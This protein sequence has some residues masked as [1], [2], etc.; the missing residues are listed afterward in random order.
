MA[1]R[2]CPCCGSYRVGHNH[3]S[4]RG[5]AAFCRDCGMTTPVF[6]SLQQAEMTWNRR[7]PRGVIGEIKKERNRQITEKDYI[8]E[9]DDALVDGQLA[10]AASVY[11]S[12][13]VG[14]RAEYYPSGWVFKPTK[15]RRELIKAAALIV[16][17]IERLDREE[18]RKN[19]SSIKPKENKTAEIFR[20]QLNKEVKTDG[21]FQKSGKSDG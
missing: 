19:D 17:E 9:H 6:S 13:R 12:T 20:R 4:P 5:V 18:D 10:D 14:D 7:N 21:N 15:R 3:M 8:Y 1:L 11:A 16:A 2:E